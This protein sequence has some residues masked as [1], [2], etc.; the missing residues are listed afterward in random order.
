MMNADVDVII[1]GA[2]LSGIGAAVH[3]QEHCPD[4]TFAI[5][6]GRNSIGGTWDLFRYPGIRSDS[7]M[8]TLGYVFKPWTEAKA[9]A[10]GPSIRKYVRETATEYDLERHIKFDHRVIAASWSS[11]DALWTLTVRD[12]DGSRDMTSRFLFMCSGYYNYEAGYT[13][14]FEGMDDYRG[15]IAHP[16]KWSSDIDYARKKVVIIGSG[17]TAVTL[18]PEMAK[19]AAHVTMLQRSP[20]YVVSRPSND[21]IAN[22]MRRILPEKWAYAAARWKNI[23]LGRFFYDR[24]QSHPEKVKKKLLDMVRKE[25]GENFNIERDFTPRY[26]PWEQRLCLVPDN[27]LFNSLKSGAASIKTDHIDRFVEQGI[28]L[29][30]GDVL[31]ADLIVTATGLD[32]QLFGGM[33]LDVDGQ[34]LGSGDLMT[35]KGLMYRDVPNFAN[36]FGYTNASWTLKADLTSQYVCRLINHLEQSGADFCVPRAPEEQAEVNDMVPLTSGYFARAVD[37]LPKEGKSEPWQQLHDYAADIK[38][39][40]H[41]DLEDGIMAF[42]NRAEVECIEGVAAE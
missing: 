10:D 13:P 31:D 8:H 41:G 7:D 35:Y 17:A 21:R 29:R 11:A 30:S 23:K 27:D 36:V 28:K 12:G 19:Q 16:Q 14:D 37:R 24:T 15:E 20:T 6:E 2:G 26:N 9:I 3:L 18:V 34:T 1:V 40:K 5:L 38:A 39:L 32:L 22:I 33:T 25:L 42:V 4:K